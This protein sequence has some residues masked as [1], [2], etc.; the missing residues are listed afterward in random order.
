MK[1][2]NTIAVIVPVFNG[3]KFIVR[4]LNTIFEQ[5]F[6]PTEVIIVDDGSK[7]KTVELINRYIADN[8][9]V[10]KYL[11]ILYQKNKGA[12]A[13]RNKALAITTSKWIAFLDSD[14]LWDKK[15][16]E[17]INEIIM[18]NPDVG[19]I[20]HDE[21]EAEENNLNSQKYIPRH[22][23]LKREDLFLQLYKGNIFSTSCMVIKKEIIEKA[24]NFDETLLSAQD[25][26][27][28]IRCSQYSNVIYLKE[29]LAT[30]IVRSD[31]I[32][33]NTYRRYK[34]EIKIYKKYQEKIISKFGIKDGKKIILKRI[35]TIHKVEL[36]L[37]LK[38]K[39]VMSFFKIFLK[40]P[41]EILKILLNL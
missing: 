15:K 31:N 2:E 29:P 1:S 35:Y 34:C 26:D 6:L 4:A 13:A 23:N 20:T 33:S 3:E 36:Y 9:K 14:D 24:G 41:I 39:Q 19:I 22:K 16:L 28:W 7:D 38:N 30:Y 17:K 18:K 10:K 5:S 21:Y 8:I 37:S 32:T 40:F 12:G 25:Y 27:L 11:K